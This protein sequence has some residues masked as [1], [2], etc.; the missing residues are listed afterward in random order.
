M[1]SINSEGIFNIHI[2][3]AIFA[4]KAH[5]NL[6]TFISIIMNKLYNILKNPTFIVKSVP[7]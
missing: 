5:N 1:I 3:N 6:N 2:K 7:V 4:I